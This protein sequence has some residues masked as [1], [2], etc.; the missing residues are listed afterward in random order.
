MEFL[1]IHNTT[2]LHQTNDFITAFPTSPKIQDTTSP[3]SKH[4]V[5]Q[6]DLFQLNSSWQGMHHPARNSLDFQMEL[7]SPRHGPGIFCSGD[8]GLFFYFLGPC[9]HKKKNSPGRWEGDSPSRQ[10]LS[11]D[12]DPALPRFWILCGNSTRLER[13]E[14]SS[15]MG[16]MQ[17]TQQF[18]PFPENPAGKMLHPEFESAEEMNSDPSCFILEFHEQNP[19]RFCSWFGKNLLEGW[20]IPHLPEVSPDVLPLTHQPQPEKS[21]LQTHNYDLICCFFSAGKTK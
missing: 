19:P 3:H 16:I 14:C 20:T 2:I 21:A 6:L 4:G 5:F 8:F 10:T 18:Q 17:Q 11:H 12:S 9:S 1:C 15:L 13:P 7:R